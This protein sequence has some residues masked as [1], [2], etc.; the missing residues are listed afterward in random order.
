MNTHRLNSYQKRMAMIEKQVPKIRYVAEFKALKAECKPLFD[1]YNAPAF[2]ASRFLNFD[3]RTKDS[4]KNV[5][6][7]FNR[8]KPLTLTYTFYYKC[9]IETEEERLKIANELK[10]NQ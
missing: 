9:D 3:A 2:N 1:V 5:H 10:L 8:T 4:L 6:E 7:R